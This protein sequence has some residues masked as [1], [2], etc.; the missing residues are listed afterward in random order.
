VLLVGACVGDQ[1]ETLVLLAMEVWVTSG[2]VPT[3]GRSL[4]EVV[5]ARTSMEEEG[6]RWGTTCFTGGRSFVASRRRRQ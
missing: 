3:Q 4:V 6:W 1:Q 2:G 5:V